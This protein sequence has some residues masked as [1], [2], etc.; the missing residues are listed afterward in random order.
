MNLTLDS[1]NGV[2]K[3]R[4]L[5]VSP[6][7]RRLLLDVE[8]S[9]ATRF[10]R[11]LWELPTDGSAPARP[12]TPALENVVAAA[13]VHDGT[14]VVA[15][16]RTDD[17]DAVDLGVVEPGGDVVRTTSIPSLRAIRIAAGI[18]VRFQLTFSSGTS[19]RREANLAC[20]SAR[21]RPWE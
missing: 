14:L 1:I 8:T 12:M 11:S 21:S 20:T 7:G 10:V 18:A 4:D 17:A 2:P 15:R 9:T 5:L 6:D 3:V 19:S 16:P 13:F